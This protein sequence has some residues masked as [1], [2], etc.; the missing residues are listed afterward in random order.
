[1]DDEDDVGF[2]P[3]LTPVRFSKSDSSRERR[4][5]AHFRFLGSGE[6]YRGL[7]ALHLK[8]LSYGCKISTISMNYIR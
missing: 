6:P 4:F 3:L 7:F 5:P 2:V 8:P 1:M